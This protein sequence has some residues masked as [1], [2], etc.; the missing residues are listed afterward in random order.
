MDSVNLS[1]RKYEARC[2][3]SKVKVLTV[4]LQVLTIIRME[5]A[6][7]E[8]N[9]HSFINRIDKL[10]GSILTKNM[11][12]LAKRDLGP[13]QGKR[14]RKRKGKKKEPIGEL[15]WWGLAENVKMEQKYRIPT[16]PRFAATCA[17]THKTEGGS[18]RTLFSHKI[19]D[20][21]RRVL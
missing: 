18:P 1:T 3:Q 16:R 21:R 4:D 15:K 19:N 8:T 13:I 2:V 9:Y 10:H 11:Q 5:N 14:K 12:I 6:A 20:L 17:K 7:V